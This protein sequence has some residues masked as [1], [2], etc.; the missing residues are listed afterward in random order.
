MSSCKARELIAI[1]EPLLEIVA[2]F[3]RKSL[4]M[5]P[6]HLIPVKSFLRRQQQ[7][8]LSLCNLHPGPD[9]NKTPA[10]PPLPAPKKAAAQPLYPTLTPSPSPKHGLVARHPRVTTLYQHLSLHL[11]LPALMRLVQR[12]H[13]QVLAMGF[14]WPQRLLTLRP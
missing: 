11:H 9:I 7:A 1:V 3:K 10:S 4:K 14:T 5:L 6:C 13:R 12:T 2:R 8:H